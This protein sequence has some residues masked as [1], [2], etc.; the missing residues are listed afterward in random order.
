MQVSGQCSGRNS[1]APA[2]AFLLLLPDQDQWLRPATWASERDPHLEG[3]G[4]SSSQPLP[5]G[6]AQ[7]GGDRRPGG[8]FC[9]TLSCHHSPLDLAQK[10]VECVF[11]S[12]L[13]LS[14]A[15]PTHSLCLSTVRTSLRQL[16]V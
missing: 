10:V 2:L 7:G 1:V 11:F 12:R 4:C 16:H 13:P 8:P 9:R 6:L 14:G 15:A 3:P 5:G